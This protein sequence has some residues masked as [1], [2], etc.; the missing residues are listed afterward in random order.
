MRFCTPMPASQATLSE[1]QFRRKEM[2]I[3]LLPRGTDHVQRSRFSLP[4]ISPPTQPRY[5][6]ITGTNL[7]SGWARVSA[8]YIKRLLGTAI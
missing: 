6:L 5:C 4:E 3:E 2:K 7:Q 1:R 8:R